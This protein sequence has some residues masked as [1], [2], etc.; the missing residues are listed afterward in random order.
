MWSSTPAIFGGGNTG[1]PVGNGMLGA[2]Q[3]GNP[4]KE[5]ILLNVDSMWSGGVKQ[6][7]EYRGGNPTSNMSEILAELREKIFLDGTGNASQMA[8]SS[9]GF[10]EYRILGNFSINIDHPGKFDDYKRSLDLETGTYRTS[11]RVDDS[12]YN[13]LL[14]CSHPSRVADTNYESRKGNKAENYR[15]LEGK[16][17]ER[18]IYHTYNAIHLT[19][20]KR[21]REQTKD[22]NANLNGF[23]LDLPDHRNSSKAETATLFARYRAEGKGDPFVESLLF[24]Y[25]RYLLLAS[26]RKRSLP[27]SVQGR[28][29]ERM[30]RERGAEYSANI[31]LQAN[32]WVAH[33]TGM[34]DT[35]HALWEFLKNTLATRG[36]ETAKLLYNASGWVAHNELNIFGYTGIKGEAEW[37]NYPISAA[38]LM[39]HV[40]D[41]FEYSQDRTFLRTT[42]Y[43]LM[44]DVSKFWLSQLQE[45]KYSKDGSL[46]ANP[47][48]SPEHGPTTFGCA[49]FQQLIHQILET[50]RRAMRHVKVCDKVFQSKLDTAISHLDKG[51]H[52][53]SQG[54]IKEWKLPESE[55]HETDDKSQHLS[56]LVGWFPGYSIASFQDGYRNS[57][58]QQAVKSSLESRGTGEENGNSSWAKAWRAACWARLNNTEQAYAHLRRLIQSNIAE[59]GLSTSSGPDSPFQMSGNMAL[60]GAILSMLVV[61][62]PLPHSRIGEAR[63]V[64]LGPAIPSMWAGG[65]VTGL[66]LRG[67]WKV[68]FS[69]DANG[70]V[71]KAELHGK[72]RGEVVLVNVDGVIMN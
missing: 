33:Q 53:T 65:K 9:E 19:M 57:T 24:D 30:D 1:Y 48:T 60:A 50:T 43:P 14:F 28:W 20:K 26:S 41:H 16:S 10:G 66:M 36:S 17:A 8:G 40:W 69:W 58:I 55:G 45:D 4:G 6:F 3:F 52:L 32:Y 54:S 62:L 47:C 70:K 2:M 61:D 71:D 49:H 12:N 63:T 68:D 44:R 7:P 34:D 37:N 18:V 56:H 64:V 31:H 39:Q 27:P 67:G 72:G 38:W 29:I 59:N 5:Q 42:G 51:L 11:Y 46:V 15:F 35:L 13:T 25:S 22:Y 23:I 21:V